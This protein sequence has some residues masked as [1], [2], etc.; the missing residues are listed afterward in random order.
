MPEEIE[1]DL[2]TGKNDLTFA[3]ASSSTMLL[4]I[5][6]NETYT[7][8]LLGALEYELFLE[9]KKFNQNSMSASHAI[10]NL[11]QNK[12]TIKLN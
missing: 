2:Y 1:Q 7:E 4:D 6:R 12:C 11:Q 5:K 8:E 10:F 3:A 9:T